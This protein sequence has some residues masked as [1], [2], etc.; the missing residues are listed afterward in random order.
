MDRYF[1]AIEFELVDCLNSLKNIIL[2]RLE[3]Q[4]S[5]AA[6]EKNEG[7]ENMSKNKYTF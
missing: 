4:R 7:V 3:F 2:K 5:F 1:K 6:Y